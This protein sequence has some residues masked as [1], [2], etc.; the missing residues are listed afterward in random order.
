M[1]LILSVLPFNFIQ[2]K[3]YVTLL[4]VIVNTVLT[5]LVDILIIAF[6]KESNTAMD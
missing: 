6:I 5:I 4:Y 1:K 3:D 2:Y